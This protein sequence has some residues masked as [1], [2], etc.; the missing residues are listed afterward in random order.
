MKKYIGVLLLSFTYILA[1]SQSLNEKIN[2]IRKHYYN[3]ENN[4]PSYSK[5]E[6]S[7]KENDYD[8]YFYF[9]N[10]YYNQNNQIVKILQY[11]GDEHS[12][13]GERTTGTISYYYNNGELFFIFEEN[14]TE[15]VYEEKSVKK[16][17][18]DRLYF[19]DEELIRALKK[20]SSEHDMSR[21]KNRN[22]V[23]L[24]N[25]KD[26][27]SKIYLESAYQTLESCKNSCQ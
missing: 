15:N 8:N 25:N 16:Y 1:T 3:I 11:T 6:C 26:Y 4:I 18:E 9:F 22:N 5:K 24:L 19:Y 17:T 7:I 2:W 20:E 13:T 14:L 10:V 27:H 21:V 23:T 12:I